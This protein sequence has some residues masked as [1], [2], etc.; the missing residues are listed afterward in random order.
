MIASDLRN[1]VKEK[2]DL[3]TIL[4]IEGQYHLPA[5]DECS[6]EFLREVLK[7]KKKLLRNRDVCP[8]NVPRYKEFNTTPLYQ[9]AFL[10][11]E[12]RP[13]FP[14]PTGSKSKPINRKFLFNVN[15]IFFCNQ[16]SVPPRGSYS[17]LIGVRCR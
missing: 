12:L 8:V 14:D 2:N 1:F 6:M 7:G 9:A 3:Y 13:Y 16:P 5:Y 4:A 17:G 11:L 15:T 10:D